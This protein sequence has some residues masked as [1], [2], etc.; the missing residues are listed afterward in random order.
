MAVT[1]MPTQETSTSVQ[2]STQETSTSVQVSTQ[3][4]TTE[5]RVDLQCTLPG[6]KLTQHAVSMYAYN[7]IVTNLQTIN[8]RTL[9]SMSTPIFPALIMA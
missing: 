6:G 9:D 4:V 2:V 8:L 3:E 1:E 5:G 7:T